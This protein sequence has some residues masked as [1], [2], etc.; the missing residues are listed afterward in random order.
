M[1]R[2]ALPPQMPSVSPFP[3]RSRS[4]Y[5]RRSEAFP[6]FPS[7]A[8]LT[9]PVLA[10]KRSPFENSLTCSVP[11]SPSVPQAFPGNARIPRSPFPPPYRRGTVGNG[12]AG[13]HWKRSPI[14]RFGM[15]KASA[16]T[17]P[18]NRRSACGNRAP[19]AYTYARTRAHHS[20]Q[21]RSPEMGSQRPISRG[22]RK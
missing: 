9:I 16:M 11:R 5:L 13:P 19:G 17:R 2:S 14:G 20:A 12:R 21:P 7:L 1:L 22:T 3:R 6:A 4:F 10:G 8:P 15:N 18:R